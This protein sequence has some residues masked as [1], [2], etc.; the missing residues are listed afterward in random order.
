VYCDRIDHAFFAAI[1][2]FL[3][4]G[5]HTC[6][7]PSSKKLYK[8]VAFF[9]HCGLELAHQ[10]QLFRFYSGKTTKQECQLFESCVMVVRNKR[11]T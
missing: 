10:A 7:I 11:R 4:C 5:K 3:C 1:M 2:P 8:S 9:F 6:N